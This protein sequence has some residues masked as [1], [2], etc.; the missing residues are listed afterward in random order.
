MRRFAIVAGLS[1]C[2]SGCFIVP[3]SRVE[4]MDF[5]ATPVQQVEPP[6]NAADAAKEAADW[7]VVNGYKKTEFEAFGSSGRYSFHLVHKE[8]PDGY[9]VVDEYLLITAGT[10]DAVLF[11]F[12]RIDDTTV[13][14]PPDEV[15]YWQNQLE[16]ALKT[17]TGNP[18]KV[19]L[20]KNTAP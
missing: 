20:V 13:K 15:Q 7:F 10:G 19:V 16:S 9:R 14:F 8:Y 4:W 12:D 1:L 3:G 18:Y 17:A 6:I 5:S 11:N 2:C